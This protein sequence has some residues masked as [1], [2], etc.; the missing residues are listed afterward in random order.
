[1]GR[2]LGVEIKPVASDPTPVGNRMPDVEAGVG[3]R[4]AGRGWAACL[5]E[6][7]A[8]YWSHS[9]EAEARAGREEWSAGC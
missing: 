6:E 2:G 1:M 7:A 5:E 3:G 9:L 8:G 4:E